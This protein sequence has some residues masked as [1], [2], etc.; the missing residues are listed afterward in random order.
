MTIPAIEALKE[1]ELRTR[2][3]RL[4]WPT[5][6][7]NALQTVVQYV[8]TAQVGQ[9]GAA[10][11][12]A[13][14]LTSTTTWLVNAPLWA[15]ATGIL[16]C[17]SQSLGAGDRERAGRAADQSLLLVLILGFAMTL[18]TLVISPF[19]P[20]W[21]G[22]DEAIRH[23]ASVYFA[24]ICAPMLCPTSVVAASPMP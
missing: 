12:A 10:A 13:V 4:A 6:T 7:E 2:I 20:V 1:K 11:S 8:D 3:F 22:A 16:A 23:D 19:L 24:V 9:L 5:V 17:I 15:V 18:L 21:L 14:G